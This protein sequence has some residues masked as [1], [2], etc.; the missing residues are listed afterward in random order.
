MKQRLPKF[1]CL[2]LLPVLLLT[3]CW[4]EELLKTLDIDPSLLGTV[5]ESCECSGYVTEAA[6]AG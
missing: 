1:I 5:L 2:L 4:S 3:G 6:A